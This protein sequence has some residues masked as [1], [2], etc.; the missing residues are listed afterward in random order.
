MQKKDDQYLR[1]RKWKEN[2]CYGRRKPLNLWYIDSGCSKHMIGDK[3]KFISFN[4]TKKE[5]N[6][7]FGNNT[8]VT[9]IGKWIVMLK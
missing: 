1:I 4:K 7:I 3:D 2:L 8:H 5:K 9:L 6:V